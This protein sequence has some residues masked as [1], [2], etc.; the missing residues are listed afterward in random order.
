MSYLDTRNALLQLVIDNVSVPIAYENVEFNNET[1]DSFVAFYFRPATSESYGKTKASGDGRLGFIQLSVYVR[2]NAVD[3]YDNGQL[4]IIDDLQSAFWDGLVFNASGQE[5]SIL[6]S[7]VNDGT[8]SG[9]WFKRD[10]TI[11]YLAITQRV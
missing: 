7:S 2:S 10:L 8:N 9:A 5:I 3:E 4:G 6:D 1:L 11:N